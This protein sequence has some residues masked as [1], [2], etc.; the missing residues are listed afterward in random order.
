VVPTGFGGA[1]PDRGLLRLRLG[2][3]NGIACDLATQF[4]SLKARQLPTR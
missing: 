3:G 4:R 1:A 2:S